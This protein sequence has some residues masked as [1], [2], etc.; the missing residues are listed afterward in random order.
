[1]AGYAGFSMSNNAVDAYERG[2]APAS[3]VAKPKGVTSKTVKLLVDPEEWHHTSKKYNRTDFYCPEAIRVAFD[4]D[5]T[6]TDDCEVCDGLHPADREPG[7][8][9]VVIAETRETIA[10]VEA[11]P[12]SEIVV[13][14]G[15]ELIP[16][17]GRLSVYVPRVGAIYS[18]PDEF[19]ETYLRALR[20]SIGIPVRHAEGGAR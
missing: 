19:R 16:A 5:P 13:L 11:T 2:I 9:A 6:G 4:P 14:P 1:M 8:A 12:D 7:Y 10:R 20:D 17:T 15:V 3:K 18:E